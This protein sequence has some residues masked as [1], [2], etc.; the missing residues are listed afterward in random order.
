MITLGAI[1]NN[2]DWALVVLYVFWLFF[3]GLV[4]HLLREGRREG[5]PL[6]DDITGKQEKGGLIWIPA[7]KKFITDHG[8]YTAPRMDQVEPEITPDRAV[9]VAPFPGAPLA[10]VGNPLKAGV[11]PGS[12]VMRAD[13]PDLTSEGTTKI[14]PMRLLPEHE[15]AEYD[16]DPREMEVVGADGMPAGIVKDLWIDRSEMLVRYM[17]VALEPGLTAPVAASQPA[18]EPVVTDS[19]AAV[20]VDEDT[21][22]VAVAVKADVAAVPAGTVLVPMNALTLSPMYGQVSTPTILARQ[23]ADAPRLAAPDQVTLLEEEKIM[24]Y[25]AAGELYA[26]PDRAEPFF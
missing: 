22:D 6:V 17:E 4:F 24:A 23:F 12:Y 20:A 10:P 15:I 2:I 13:R 9:P 26:T 21:G 18:P 3:A 8:V 14:V 1:T 7:P 19:D 5:Y 16:A 11:G 25:F